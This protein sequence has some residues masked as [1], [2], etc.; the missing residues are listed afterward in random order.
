MSH[1]AQDKERFLNEQ[2]RERGLQIWNTVNTGKPTPFTPSQHSGEMYSNAL[3][4]IKQGVRAESDFI[5][6][7]ISPNKAKQV[8]D[9]V[10]KTEFTPPAKKLG[11]RS[12]LWVQH[13]FLKAAPH[14]VQ[15]Q[16]FFSRLGNKFSTLGSKIKGFFTR[17]GKGRRVARRA[18]G[19]IERNK[20]LRGGRRRHR[21]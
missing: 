11:E 4:A 18:T 19:K 7:A 6:N 15:R 5:K 12:N 13:P 9:L 16:G 2:Q 10:K 20:R 3:G 14:T 8:L 17:S 1:F 21:R